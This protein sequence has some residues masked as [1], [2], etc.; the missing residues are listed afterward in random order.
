MD[1]IFL[2]S[3]YRENMS[4]LSKLF[5]DQKESPLERALWWVEWVLRNPSTLIMQSNA[6]RLDW[7]VKYS[8]DVIVPLV[9]MGVVVLLMLVNIARFVLCRKGK[10][11]KTKR[12]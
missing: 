12:E 4:S 6:V 9:F 2:I 7:L 1:N 10:Q 11:S 3:S 5:R 8:F